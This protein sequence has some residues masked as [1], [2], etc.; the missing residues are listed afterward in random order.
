MTAKT[1]T[2]FKVKNPLFYSFFKMHCIYLGCCERSVCSTNSQWDWFNVITIERL[3]DWHCLVSF[4]SSGLRQ[5]HLTDSRLA[6]PW[7]TGT[8]NT[9]IHKMPVHVRNW[10]SETRV[11]LVWSHVTPDGCLKKKKKK[12]PVCEWRRE[13][14]SQGEGD[15]KGRRL[16][17]PAGPAAVPNL[18]QTQ[19]NNV[20]R[21]TV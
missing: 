6:G 18:F 4:P 7:N 20:T 16:C 1:C 13:G 11:F 19:N 21:V 3:R 14:V 5:W 2:I 12:R 15:G 17:H 8:T 9:F 10:R